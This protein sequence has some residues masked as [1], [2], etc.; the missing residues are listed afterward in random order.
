MDVIT[1][2][3]PENHILSGK[4][5]K[6]NGR[7]SS[8][9]KT[10]FNILSFNPLSKLN[11][12][13]SAA[14]KDSA[15]DFNDFAVG[16]FSS[17]GAGRAYSS[18]KTFS[19]GDIFAN[20]YPENSF[21]GK[22]I[23][24]QVVGD[25]VGA[26]RHFFLSDFRGGLPFFGSCTA[27][28]TILLAALWICAP[29]LQSRFG[30]H[31]LEKFS[32]K[33]DGASS[34]AMNALLSGEYL[35]VSAILQNGTEIT[36]AEQMS[37]LAADLEIV[38]PVSYSDYTVKGG[39]TVSGVAM[40]FGLNN[41][42]TILSVN[43][44]ENARRIRS[45]Q[46]LRIPSMDGILYTVAKGDSVSSVSDKFNVSLSNIL[47]ANDLTDSILME[48]QELFIPGATLSSYTRKAH[49]QIRF[50][51]GSFHRG[52]KLPHRRGSGGSDGDIDKGFL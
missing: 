27:V 7:T 6:G 38:S 28:L 50:Q 9:A 36:A 45:G 4:M 23:F 43:G 32:F 13:F 20:P 26:F 48:G 41:I 18:G 31:R 29:V 30:F 47:D 21:G 14:K 52:E 3:Q 1:I 16:A 34:S 37:A 5:K 44:I 11:G 42:S 15:A 22:T 49:I 10:K 12:L 2:L 24:R 19:A 8:S 40:R 51:G 17:A 39:D 25:F 33:D 35:P 46:K